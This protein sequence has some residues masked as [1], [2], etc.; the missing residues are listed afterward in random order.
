MLDRLSVPRRPLDFEDYIDILRRNLGWLIAP[1]F[2]GLVISTVVAFF[3]PDLYVSSALIRVVPQQVAPD[4]VK[5]TSTQDIADRINSMAQ[6][7]LSRNTLANII[8][9]YGLYKDQLKREPMDDAV[10]AMKTSHIG[11]GPGAGTNV[12]GKVTP[13]M[14]VAFSDGDPHMA[15]RVTQEL[16]SRFMNAGATGTLEGEL[17][18]RQYFEDELQQAKQELDADEKK[19]ADFRQKNAGRLPDE[20]QTNLQ[21]MN[22]LD[23]RLGSLNSALMRNNEQRMMLQSELQLAKERL[24]AIKNPVAQAQNEKVN[25]LNRQIENQE[26]TIMALKDRYTDDY[27]DLQDARGRL[28][29][30]KRLRDQAVEQASKQ[31]PSTDAPPDNPIVA[32]D[33]LEAQGSIQQL[34]TQLKANEIERQAFTKDVQNVNAALRAYQSRL[35]GVAGEKEYSDL[36]RDRELAKQRYIDLQLKRERSDMSVDLQRRKQGETL[37]LIDGASLPTTPTK[38]NRRMIVPIGTVVG[39]GLALF[40]VAIREVRDTSLKNLKDARLYTQLSILG[41]VPLLENDV[42]VQRRK[43][44]MWI[45]WATATVVGLAMMAGSIA[46]YFLNKA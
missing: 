12:A 33:R 21:Q 5:N 7:I 23:E 10:L 9:Q 22:A 3:I 25:E 19:L 43:Q 40:L 2:A 18:V 6:N 28:D 31:K 39:L 38:P 41:S 15:Q 32:R 45:G 42:V 26:T 46:H 44:V 11:I 29:F 13:T 17:S 37:E 4:L 8:T 35:E 20:V 14:V 34:Q 24:A 1:T 27:P 16:V 30:L 36:L